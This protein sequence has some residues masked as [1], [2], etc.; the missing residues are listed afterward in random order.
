[1]RP[2]MK[3]KWNISLIFDPHHL[4]C[5]DIY[6]YIYIDDMVEVVSS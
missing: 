4:L 5:I 2:I 3:V 1:M 6:I